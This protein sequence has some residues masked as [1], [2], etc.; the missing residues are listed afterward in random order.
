MNKKKEF[1]INLNAVPTPI[2]FFI[3]LLI[4]TLGLSSPVHSTSSEKEPKGKSNSNSSGSSIQ[5]KPQNRPGL[6]HPGKPSHSSS[7][8][9]LENKNRSR[10][11]GQFT[12]QDRSSKL[13]VRT[14]KVV[15]HPP[16]P[17]PEP[18]E[19]TPAPPPEKPRKHRHPR[20]PCGGPGYI[21]P[22]SG[23]DNEEDL[24]APDT[25]D[26]LTPGESNSLPAKEYRI[27]DSFSLDPLL[28]R[29]IDAYNAKH[30][31]RDSLEY[32]RSHWSASLTYQL[33]ESLELIEHME[34]KIQYYKQQLEAVRNSNLSPAER[35]AK[36][37]FWLERMDRL[38]ASKHKEE[39]R[40]SELR[41]QIT[42]ERRMLE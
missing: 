17:Q 25:E 19:P 10:S 23:N 22:V 16:A 42:E 31:N 27:N 35:S 18:P 9:R 38:Q 20:P 39:E 26:T 15:R 14:G 37:L 21:V 33:L 32:P 30:L 40:V 12:P 29:K 4:I 5:S 2:F 11:G 6:A 41:S 8:P 7:A 28:A 1:I 3:F 36:E 34:D 24:E 13:K